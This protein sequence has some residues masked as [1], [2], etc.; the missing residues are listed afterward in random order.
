MNIAHKDSMIFYFLGE[1]FPANENCSETFLGP[2]AHI[3]QNLL[4]LCLIIFVVKDI[5]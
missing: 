2:W 4:V 1:T 5:I 3:Y